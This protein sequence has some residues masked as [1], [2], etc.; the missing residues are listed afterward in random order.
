MLLIKEVKQLCIDDNNLE[1]ELDGNVFAIDANTIDQCL[2]T[3]Y[4]ATFRIT[5]A[6]IKIYNQ[7]NLETA[8]P[9]FLIFSKASVH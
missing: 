9:E 7:I 2:S 8:I 6:G 3:F 4:L 5:K 1:L